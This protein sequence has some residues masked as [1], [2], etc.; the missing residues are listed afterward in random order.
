VL[1]PSGATS[2]ERMGDPHPIEDTDELRRVG[3]VLSLRA[4]TFDDTSWVV[5]AGHIWTR[6]AQPWFQFGADDI[7][8][9]AQPTD[10][11]PIIEKFKAALSFD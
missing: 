2:V 7:R 11:V 1:E 9:D 5:P 10:Y 4:G 6:S 3:G 8:R